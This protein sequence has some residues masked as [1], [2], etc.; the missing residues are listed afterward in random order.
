VGFLLF[1]I[2]SFALSYIEGF[3]D[4]LLKGAIFS[5]LVFPPLYLHYSDKEKYRFELVKGD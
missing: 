5:G 4:T 2:G 3:T 1:L